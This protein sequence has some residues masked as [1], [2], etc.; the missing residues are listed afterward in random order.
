MS[1]CRIN[2]QASVTLLYHNNKY[3]RTYNDDYNYELSRNVW[4]LYKE[5]HKFIEQYKRKCE[6]LG[7]HIAFFDWHSIKL[8]FH[9]ISSFCIIPIKIWL[10]WQN[11]NIK[12][13]FKKPEKFKK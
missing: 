6:W 5:N 12:E 10:A 9:L 2:T 4:H 8:S 3:V 13:W 11:L 7:V 1:G